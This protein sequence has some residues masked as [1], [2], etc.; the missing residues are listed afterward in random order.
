MTKHEEGRHLLARC[1]SD[2]AAWVEAVCGDAAGD[3]GRWIDPNAV[4][5]YALL[6][7]LQ[8]DLRTEDRA[9]V[10]YLFEQEMLR[11][12]REPFQGLH[13]ALC[14][15][16]Y[17]LATDRMVEHVWLFAGAKLANFDTYLGFDLEYL[18][19]AGIEGTLAFVRAADTHPLRKD[20][21]D[22]L[23]GNDGKCVLNEDQLVSW[24]RR[25]EAD[26]PAQLSDEQPEVRLN[27]ALGL[28][29][30]VEARRWLETWEALLSRTSRRLRTVAWYWAQ[31]REWD[32]AGAVVAEILD[33]DDLSAWDRASLQVQ[34]VSYHREAGRTAEAGRQLLAARRTLADIEAWWSSGLGRSATEEALL[35]VQ[36]L[37]PGNEEADEA[38]RW[39][40]EQLK[41]HGVATLHLLQLA[42][43]AAA[44][45][46]D[47][48]GHARY[49]QLARKER[50]RIDR[51]LRRG[52]VHESDT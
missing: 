4:P 3:D 9:L 12:R 44:H 40:C 46:G 41:R 2:P 21:L 19:S 22:W 45:V 1:R 32:R 6:L 42:E 34:A 26:F 17:L 35:I 50:Q 15:A 52:E 14:L 29:D 5:R 11:H 18:V 30:L 24:W 28:N 37:P 10:R 48:K 51:M 20:V 47:K 39:A 13:P 8:Y 23:V 43:S 16:G 38:Y 27:Q 7:A 49:S 31:V 33:H 25:V 36:A